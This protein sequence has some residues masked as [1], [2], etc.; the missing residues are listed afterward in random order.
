MAGIVRNTKKIDSHNRVA[1]PRE[2]CEAGEVVFFEITKSGNLIIRKIK[3]ENSDKKI[4][5]NS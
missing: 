2:W 3:A 4:S 5:D 1:L